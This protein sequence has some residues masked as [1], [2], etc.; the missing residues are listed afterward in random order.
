MEDMAWLVY[1]VFEL[2]TQ[3]LLN[4]GQEPLVA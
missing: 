1:E 4:L 2:S 3:V